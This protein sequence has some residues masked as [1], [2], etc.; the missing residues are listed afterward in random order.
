MTIRVE[1]ISD[2]SGSLEDVHT[3]ERGPVTL[4]RSPRCDVV[5][6]TREVSRRQLVFEE[7][8]ACWYVKHLG[9]MTPTFL[10]GASLLPF[11][12]LRLSD[13]DRVAV[14]EITLAIAIDGED[15]W[16]EGDGHDTDALEHVGTVSLEQIGG[17]SREYLDGSRGED[18]VLV[19]LK[20]GWPTRELTLEDGHTY[21][22]GRSAA[23]D[24]QV[25]DMS[26]SRRHVEIRRQG[27]EVKVNDLRAKYGLR[28]NDVPVRG[29]VSMVHGDT[30]EL[31][32]ASL[33]FEWKAPDRTRPSQAE[34]ATGPVDQD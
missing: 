18:A 17:R 26:V 21:V 16:I 25:H 1:V 8:N 7:L 6:G 34:P 19:L 33:R 32:S 4:G 11:R 29:E 24:F 28:I 31:G 5:F 22:L 20:D 9:S 3:F 27:R 12:P 14:E 10:N 30:L 15:A 13:G 23:C 2:K